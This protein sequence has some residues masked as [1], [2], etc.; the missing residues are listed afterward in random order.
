M[1]IRPAR[2]GAHAPA[3]QGHLADAAA[4]YRECQ[5]RMYLKYQDAVALLTQEATEV[6][7]PIMI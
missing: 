3:L 6:S 7:V 5:A 4:E 1:P 2:R